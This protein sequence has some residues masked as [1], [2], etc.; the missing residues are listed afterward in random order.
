MAMIR[1]APVFGFG[2]DGFRNHC[3]DPNFFKGSTW[4]GVSDA[5]ISPVD[6]CNIHPH[7]YWLD[8]AV[9]G[10]LVGLAMFAGLAVLWL[11]RIGR[12]LVPAAEPMR[13]ALLVA[14][15]VALWPLASTSSLFVADTGGWVVFTIGWGL[16]LAE[17]A[18]MG[19]P[20]R[21]GTL[22]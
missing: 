19:E 12:N 18:A 20:H 5:G 6:G 11:R 22:T 15:A 14:T 7:N 17:A 8:V 1:A 10:G 2:L 4:L 9:S 13:L 16:A 3:A 21:W